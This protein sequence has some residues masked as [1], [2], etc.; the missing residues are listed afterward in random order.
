MILRRIAYFFS[1]LS[2]VLL[3]VLCGLLVWE[4]NTFSLEAKYLTRIARPMHFHLEAGENSNSRFPKYG[5][6]DQRLGYVALPEFIPRLTTQHFVVAQQARMSRA[7]RQM[8]DTG[9]NLPYHEKTQAGLR[10]LDESGL[11]YYHHL[12]PQVHIP[13]FKAVPP[14]LRDSLL[15]V[16]NHDLLDPPNQRNPAVEWNRLAQ[17]IFDKL[18]K[19]VDPGRNVPGGST[20]ATQIEKFRHSRDGLTMTVQDKWQQMASASVRAYLDGPDTR[21]T[22]ERVLL[23]YLNNVPLSAAPGSGEV[24]GLPDGLSAWYGLDWDDVSTRLWANQPDEQT[25][26]VYKHAL[27]L[28]IAQRK[29]SYFLTANRDALENLTDAY[30]RLLAHKGVITPALRDR[31]LAVKLQFL[32]RPHQHN[33]S[34]V[35]QKAANATRT[36][37]SNLLE[38]PSLYAVDKLDLTAQTSL[39]ALAQLRVSQFLLGLYDPE[40]TAAAG[41]YGHDLLAP[42]D[43][44]GHIMYS[45]T[46]YER[47]PQGAALRIQADSLNQPFDIN[48]GAKLDL[49]STAKLRTL[50]TYL[51][52]VSTL[53]DKF[54]VMNSADLAAMRNDDRD[55]I[56][57]WALDWYRASPDKSLMTMLQAAMARQY[58][59]NPNET[60]FTGGGLHHF[61]NFTKDE[62]SRVMDL[63]EA[64]RNSVNLVYIRLM[65][66]IVRYEI[67]NMPGAAANI[68]QDVNNPARRTYLERFADR[69]GQEFMLRFYKKY[70]GQS[71]D[72]M[73]NTV[74]SEVHPSARRLAALYRYLAPE[75]PLPQFKL[76]LRAQSLSPLDD[77][78]IAALYQQFAPGTFSLTDLG[79]IV[80]IHPLELWLVGYLRHHPGTTFRQAVAA[81]HDQRIAV[82]DWLFHTGRKNAQDVRIHSLLEVEAF[83]QIHEQW[84]RLGYP[85]DSLVPSFATALG[86]SADRPDALAHLM[87]ILVNDGKSLPEVSIQALGFA[88]GT[89]YETDF[90]YQAPASSRMLSPELTQVVRTALAGVVQSGTAGRLN[91]VYR[92]S[93]GQVLPMGGKT[94]TGDHRF[95]TFDKQG[96]VLTSKVVDRTAT[97]VFYIGDRFFG[98]MTA[99][100]HGE[101]GAN[102]HFTSA[103][104]AQLMKVMSPWLLSDF[105]PVLT[106]TAPKPAANAPQISE[107]GAATPMVVSPPLTH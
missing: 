68:L 34:F 38:M 7:M 26:I 22:R 74:I 17:A 40:K 41:M 27:S 30:L 62:N 78:H 53:H 11:S 16:E 88:Q 10:L 86:V 8:A 25:G 57:T 24:V 103:L 14:V 39:N 56:S 63:W 60:F 54:S 6:F 4:A 79:Y 9:L 35:T 19:W 50:I 83:E 107:L 75:Q 96:N 32:V 1:G 65:R 15:W 91:G 33:T 52:I 55:P 2:V 100:V 49:G 43:D 58:S 20:L 64:T 93:A 105:S 48:R 69:E 101:V 97:F 21:L 70:R 71:P 13:S 73:T 12:T 98:T 59:A 31:A 99:V 76:F 18:I 85:F 77:A 102:Y 23:D 45:F 61:V 72:Q 66:D 89:P 81:S 80:Q 94:G 95:D 37:L 46:L 90:H 29:P 82:Y 51:E 67:A 36:N 28:L 84:K 3:A 47:T 44:L 87:G 92:D 5:P 42:G 104:P 106:P